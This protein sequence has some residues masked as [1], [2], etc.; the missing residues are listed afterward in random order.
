MFMG[1]S[2]V[3]PKQI[4]CVGCGKP[5]V[6]QVLLNVYAENIFLHPHFELVCINCG[7]GSVINEVKHKQ[8]TNIY[9]GEST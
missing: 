2:K 4:D 8:N 1:S 7:F 5:L 3:F 6:A 9:K